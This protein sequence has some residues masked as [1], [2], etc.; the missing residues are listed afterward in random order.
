MGTGQRLAW[1]AVD[2]TATFPATMDPN[3]L[4]TAVKAAMGTAWG[5]LNLDG[6]TQNAA[7]PDWS[8]DGQTIAYTSAG[9]V[10]DGRL[11]QGGEYD[12]ATV[13]YNNRQGGTV[14]KIN[15]ASQ[16]G[17]AEYY[18][19][20]SADDKFI[21]F[22]RS[23]NQNGQIYYRTDGEVYVIP[24][25]GGTAVRLAANDPPACGGEMSPGVLNSWPRWSPKVTSGDGKSYYFLVFSSARQYPGAFLVP[26]NQ[27]SAQDNRA[28]QLYMT[29][30]VVDDM[31]GNVTTY[32]AVYIWNQT[33]MTS[34]LTPAWNDFQIPPAPPLR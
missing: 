13:P 24:S 12:L 29:S 7:T 11:T 17:I 6:E 3:M 1:F 8:H 18:P 16:P 34:N 4:N 22:N 15:G 21:A 26:K 9:G 33:A 5:F 19:A 25:A 2:T 27:Y 32:G 10:Q 14:A 28:S 20:F 31:T 30:I 23:G